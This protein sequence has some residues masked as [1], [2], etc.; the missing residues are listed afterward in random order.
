ML[1]TQS[2]DPSDAVM[3]FSDLDIINQDENSTDYQKTLGRDLGN[4]TLVVDVLLLDMTTNTNHTI[5]SVTMTYK[6]NAFV[7]AMEISDI[8]TDNGGGPCLIT[9]HKY[10]GG[11]QEN[12]TSN[13]NMR[14]FTV[15]EFT[16]DDRGLEK[17]LMT[18][19]YE[20]DFTSTPKFIWRD[21][22]NTITYEALA[23]T[24]GT[25]T[26][27]ATSAADVTHRGPVTKV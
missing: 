8:V 13:L 11:I 25:G 24:G 4:T 18:Q 15:L 22:Q 27:P 6:P 14:T 17:T 26:N 2:I 3:V 9:G 1:A 21:S 23:Y 19:G 12:A 20:L 16:V 5:S 7:W 10:T